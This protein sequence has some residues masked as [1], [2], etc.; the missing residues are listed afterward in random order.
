M[1]QLAAAVLIAVITLIG[2]A[3][4][5]ALISARWQ[6]NQ[7]EAD[8]LHA[9][10]KS[11]MEAHAR[12]NGDAIIV[13]SRLDIATKTGHIWEFQR[14]EMT[15]AMEAAQQ[16][17]VELASRVNVCA[18]V[19]EDPEAST[20]LE[21]LVEA[22]RELTRALGLI[23]GWYSSPSVKDG[24]V[25]RVREGTTHSAAVETIT[26]AMDNLIEQNRRFIRVARVRWRDLLDILPR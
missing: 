14:Q 22:A 16:H 4:V 5:A 3:A 23:Q 21:D 10:F 24:I 11:V 26:A 15:L 20:A 18:G 9:A 2:S 13:V 7:Y 6:R 8:T 1:S 12:L 19:M 25:I 17:A